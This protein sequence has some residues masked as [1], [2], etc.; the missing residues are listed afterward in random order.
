MSAPAQIRYLVTDTITQGKIPVDPA[1]EIFGQITLPNCY[2]PACV[3]GISD[4]LNA[5]IP[6]IIGARQM[7]CIGTGKNHLILS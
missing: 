4:K 5:S 7:D 6:I 1:R 3:E 2:C